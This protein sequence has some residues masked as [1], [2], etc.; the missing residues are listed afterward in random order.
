MH[1]KFQLQTQSRI[2]ERERERD[3][4]K[5]SLHKRDSGGVRPLSPPRHN[6]TEPKEPFRARGSICL[7]VF[8]YYE[9]LTRTCL[10]GSSL[11][12]LSLLGFRVGSSL[13]GI[14]FVKPFLFV[15]LYF[16]W[17]FY[18]LGY[19]PQ[20]GPFPSQPILGSIRGEG[21][22]PPTNPSHHLR[23]ERSLLHLAGSQGKESNR[24][25]HRRRR[26]DD[27]HHSLPRPRVLHCCLR[28]CCHPQAATA[29]ALVLLPPLPPPPPLCRCRRRR[30]RTATLPSPPAPP[31]REWLLMEGR[32]RSPT[33]V[34]TAA[35]PCLR[36]TAAIAATTATT[37]CPGHGYFTI[38]SANAA[39]P[40]PPLPP[41]LCCCR[42]RR[43]CA[44]AAAALV[45][46]P[47]P[48][49]PSP[50]RRAA[51][52]SS[53]TSSH[54]SS[55]S[56]AHPSPSSLELLFQ[57]PPPAPP[58]ARSP[59]PPVTLFLPE[60]LFDS[61]SRQSLSSPHVFLRQNHLPLLLPPFRES[62]PAS[63]TSPTFSAHESPPCIACAWRPSHFP[64]SSLPSLPT[65]EPQ[66]P[67]PWIFPL[68]HSNR[69][70]K[71]RLPTSHPLRES[72]LL[73]L[74]LPH[75][76][77]PTRV[78]NPPRWSP[79]SP[80]AFLRGRPPKLRPSPSPNSSQ[81]SQ[82]ERL[83][84][85]PHPVLPLTP[86]DFS[87]LKFSPKLIRE[88]QRLFRLRFAGISQRSC[89]FLA[90]ETKSSVP[91]RC[92]PATGREHSPLHRIRPSPPLLS[93]SPPSP[94]YPPLA[95]R[96]LYP[97]HHVDIVTRRNREVVDFKRYRVKNYT[98]LTNL[99]N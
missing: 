29:T 94:A 58:P 20:V 61:I 55:S 87:K 33:I 96:E 79:P 91:S 83:T 38:V 51:I 60:P 6:V 52:S 35:V 66:L 68:A 85:H 71:S 18:V 75:Y 39:I 36:A 70:F 5:E 21:T 47:L 22:P 46:L 50:D 19:G 8:L 45:L 31:F 88:A 40:K 69:E 92:H 13:F 26:R 11:I 37:P 78:G 14:P 89:G 16:L 41:P 57:T 65:R 53:S 32:G 17:V 9:L 86:F 73:N 10:S 48:P 80:L 34:A 23:K 15:N 64:F 81:I 1:T 84:P 24:C 30:H 12:S 67:L 82:S 63:A 27:C 77:N 76:P 28:Q 98:E 49:P 44:T 2:G 56:Q 62:S 97:L 72:Y 90:N 43:P 42:R 4:E 7:S 25:R 54:R 74:S 59:L 95:E 93:P 99:G 3:D